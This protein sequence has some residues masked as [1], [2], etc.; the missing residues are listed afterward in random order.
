MLAAAEPGLETNT[1][2]IKYGDGATAWNSLPYAPINPNVSSNLVPAIDAVYNLGSPTH[3]WNELY[4]TGNTIYLGNMI[5]SEQNGQFYVEGPGWELDVSL[6]MADRGADGS[7]WNNLTTMG[8]YTVNRNSW[9]GV[10]GAPYDCLIFVGVLQVSTTTNGVDTSITQQ[11][12][13][14]QQQAEVTTQFI[15]SSW[16]GV[17]TTWHKVVNNDQTVSGGEF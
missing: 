8:V 7:N 3:R 4:L 16:N 1:G 13:P 11:F 6:T 14:G 9:A 15:R 17:W 10:T 2:L 5:L 12:F